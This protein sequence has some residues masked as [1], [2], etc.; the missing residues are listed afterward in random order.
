MPPDDCLVDNDSLAGY[1]KFHRLEEQKKKEKQMTSAK[2][3]GSSDAENTVPSESKND[4]SSDRLPEG[5]QVNDGSESDI[6]MGP[7]ENPK[8]PGQ[9]TV[10]DCVVINLAGKKS[11]LPY[12]ARV[13]RQFDMSKDKN[14]NAGIDSELEINL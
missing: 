13:D 5:S 8:N 9:A 7:A 11:T 2:D 4:I 1:Y 14:K 12:V 10:G 6:S 3:N